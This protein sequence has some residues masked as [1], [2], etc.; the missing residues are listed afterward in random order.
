MIVLK[1]I[2]KYYGE[3]SEITKALDGVNLTIKKS[4]FLSIMGPSGS[5]KSTLLNIIGC[6]DRPTSGEYYLDGKD[7][8]KLNDKDLSRIR[9]KQITFV[10]QNFALME[11]YTVLENIELPLLPR[12]LNRRKR[13]ELIFK[14]ASQL[15]IESQLK[16]MPYQLSRGQQQRVALARALI[17]GADIIL[18]DEPTGALDQ[19]NGEELMNIFLKLNKLGKTIILVTHDLNVAK[20]SKRIIQI[21]D[22]RIMKDDKVL[23]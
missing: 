21:I 15:G 23:L 8:T 17:S 10:F 16:K 6:M 13:K 1:D 19:K 2:C 3:G 20:F 7:M 18:A 9:N 11:K 14:A 4:E 22:G 12:N 5:G